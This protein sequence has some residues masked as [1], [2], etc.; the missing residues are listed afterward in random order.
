MRLGQAGL[1]PCLYSQTTSRVLCPEDARLNPFHA[2][3][4]AGMY[5]AGVKSEVLHAERH[6][7][8]DSGVFKSSW[9]VRPS[10]FRATFIYLRATGG[11]GFAGLMFIHDSNVADGK[12]IMGTA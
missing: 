7:I 6:S 5:S 3:R 11:G 1:H 12:N 9:E 8:S 2:I 10:S 4:K